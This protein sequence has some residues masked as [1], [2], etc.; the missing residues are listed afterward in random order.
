MA[1]RLLL[2]HNIAIHYAVIRIVNQSLSIWPN[3]QSS[4]GLFLLVQHKVMFHRRL[5][6]TPTRNPTRKHPGIGICV[7]DYGR[8]VH[9][10]HDV[11]PSQACWP[12]YQLDV[13][14]K[15][16]DSQHKRHFQICVFVVVNHGSHM[17]GTAFTHIIVLRVG[18][19]TCMNKLHRSATLPRTNPNHTYPGS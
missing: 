9:Y 18:V 3:T 6:D 12:W 19:P 15:H 2:Q 8:T 14:I 16:T 17:W 7:E 13:H 4:T 1:S 10:K 11:S 5:A